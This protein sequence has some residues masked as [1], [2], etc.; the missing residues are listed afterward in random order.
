MKDVKTPHKATF[1]IF[2]DKAQIKRAM[3]L[4]DSSGFSRER[5][6]TFFPDH[7]GNQDF[8]QVQKSEALKYARLGALLGFTLAAGTIALITLGV[9]D[10]AFAD[11]PAL[12]TSFKI[13]LGV[14]GLLIGL[15]FGA[16][17]GAMV[18]IGTPQR[19]GRRHG[20]YVHAGGLL[21]SMRSL[22]DD[23]QIKVETI[24]ETSGAQDITSM[25]EDQGWSDV[26]REH[27]RLEAQT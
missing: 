17:A 19:A 25:D 18:G 22:T 7:A 15:S 27:D 26:F 16:G 23:E 24:F 2:K 13:L 20:Q 9:A 1:G 14:G 12:S 6:S 4:L 21:L 5:M 10:R 11:V 3:S 8:A